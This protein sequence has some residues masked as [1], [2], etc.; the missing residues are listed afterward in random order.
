MPPLN[1]LFESLRVLSC[2]SNAYQYIKLLVFLGR[3]IA[4]EKCK[5]IKKSEKYQ[6]L[7]KL[8]ILDNFNK[9]ML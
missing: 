2:K 1:K 9:V 5:Q 3:R 7:K 4:K 8:D 6:H